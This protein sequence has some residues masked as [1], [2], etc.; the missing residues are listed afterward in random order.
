MFKTVIVSVPVR[1]MGVLPSLR[2]GRLRISWFRSRQVQETSIFSKTF[3]PALE[4][5]SLLFSGYWGLF[6]LG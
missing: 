1:V 3:R 6:T 5:T 4:P 2:D